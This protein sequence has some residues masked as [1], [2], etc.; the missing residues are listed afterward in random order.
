MRKWTLKILKRLIDWLSVQYTKILPNNEP[1]LPYHS[2]S[3]TD[4]AEKVEDYLDTIE[5]ALNNRDKIVTTQ[6]QS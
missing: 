2:L 5:W 3:P 6:Q 1:D 4:E